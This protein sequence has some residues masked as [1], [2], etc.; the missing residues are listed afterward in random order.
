MNNKSEISIS[1][2][3][4][5]ICYYFVNIIVLHTFEPETKEKVPWD[6]FF[7]TYPGLS[8]ITAILL[9]LGVVFWGAKLIQIFW[10]RSF[11]DIFKIRML[12]FQE[13]LTIAI[14]LSFGTL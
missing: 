1:F 3:L 8:I 10:N 12:S 2:N 11:S 5:L 7:D 9:Y 14:I 13:S 6:I 4:I